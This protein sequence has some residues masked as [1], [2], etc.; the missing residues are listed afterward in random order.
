MDPERLISVDWGTT[1]LR[2]CLVQCDPFKLIQHLDCPGQGIQV[3]NARV[4]EASASERVSEFASVLRSSLARLEHEQ[5]GWPV[6]ISG[7]ASSSIGMKELPYQTLP[8]LL[9]AQSLEPEALPPSDDFQHPTYLFTGLCDGD[10]DVMRGEETQVLGLVDLPS[11]AM[12]VVPGTHSKHIGVEGG[13]IIG[14]RTF[15][16]GELFALMSQHSIL[17]HSVVCTEEALMNETAFRE[18]VLAGARE[19]LLASLF[20]VR[21][22]CLFERRGAVDNAD[23]LSGLLIGSELASLIEYSGQQLILCGG[24]LTDAYSLAFE[25]LGL[26]GALWVIP[27]SESDLATARMHAAWWRAQV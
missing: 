22:A 15:M 24:R 13:A 11:D 14:F 26:G 6:L 1:S 25:A 12:V 21:T 3:V 2:I 17:R 18:G 8:M 20:G 19:P 5:S 16:T 27:E 9:K 10:R 4:A 7:M 23:Y